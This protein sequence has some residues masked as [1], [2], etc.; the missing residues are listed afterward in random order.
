MNIRVLSVRSDITAYMYRTMTTG[1]GHPKARDCAIYQR[2]RISKHLIGCP[3]PAVMMATSFVFGG[4]SPCFDN[5]EL[6]TT[7]GGFEDKK[8][9]NKLLF[10][11]IFIDIPKQKNPSPFLSLIFLVLVQLI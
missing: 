9:Q 3:K 5:H 2:E 8:V 6:L 11:N 1:I 4:G 7:S 10:Y